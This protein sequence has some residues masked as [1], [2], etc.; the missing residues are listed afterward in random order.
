MGFVLIPIFLNA[1]AILVMAIVATKDKM[2]LVVDVAPD[3]SLSVLQFDL[4]ILAF[5]TW[6]AKSG[7]EIYQFSSQMLI[8]LVGSLLLSGYVIADGK[9]NW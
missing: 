1:H 8:W 9:S 7:I 4:P 3:S 2:S 5:V 6:G